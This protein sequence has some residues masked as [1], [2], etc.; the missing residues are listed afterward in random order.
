MSQK[1]DERPVP[2]N[3]PGP[4]KPPGPPNPPPRPNPQRGPK[5]R[6]T[7]Q[8]D[9]ARG[10]GQLI[11]RLM[12]AGISVDRIPQGNGETIVKAIGDPEKHGK[13][14]LAKDMAR[15]LKGVKVERDA[16]E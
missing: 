2:P 6:I 12:D 1:P 8:A 16:V 7:F 15:G 10:R 3:P 14:S 4:P 11:Q 13:S 5:R 9:D